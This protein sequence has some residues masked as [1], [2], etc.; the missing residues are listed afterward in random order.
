[1]PADMTPH[2]VRRTFLAGLLI[3]LPLFITYMLIAFLFNIFTGV[4]APLVAG[5]LGII[6]ANSLAYPLVS[7][8][9]LLLSLAVIF[10]LG[11]VGT[12]I[13][14]RQMLARFESL[15]LRVPLVKTIYSSA[16]Q[17]VET[18]QTPGGSFQRVVLIQYPRQGVWSIGLVATERVDTLNLVP[19]NKVLAVFVP[20]TPNP[21]SGYLVIVSPEDVIDVDFTVEEAFKFIVSGG[22]VGKDFAAPVAL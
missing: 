16:K 11:L 18:F 20:T 13:L 14:G 3:L 22:I 1:M 8:I 7:V 12:N 9:N 4:G 15:L 5:F 21:T 2:F 10:L 19:G 6:G 17:V